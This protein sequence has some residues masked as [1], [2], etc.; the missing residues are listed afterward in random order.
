MKKFALALLPAFILY[1]SPAYAWWGGPWSQ[2]M[3]G[4]V[5]ATG[6]FEGVMSGVNLTGVMIFG[7]APTSAGFTTTSTASTATTGNG[8]TTASTLSSL[9]GTSGNEGRTAIFVQ[10]YVV[11]GD[12]SSTVD[13][14]NRT[15]TGVFQAS[16]VRSVQMLTKTFTNGAITANATSTENFTF[17]DVEEVAGDFNATFDQTFP[18]LTFVGS[19]S[20]QVTTPVEPY[21]VTEMVVGASLDS[22]ATSAD[23]GA[24]TTKFTPILQ[25][26]TYSITVNG[27]K[28]S[29]TAPNFDGSIQVQQSSVTQGTTGG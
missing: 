4:N 10:G 5:S 11:V 27:V 3:P 18:D 19:G 29:N 7:Y 16:K 17:T 1:T 21:G 8:T 22:N 28:T 26:Q 25:T 12:L 6:T 15:I 13:F 23:T 9:L 20:L 14:S 2:N 24:V